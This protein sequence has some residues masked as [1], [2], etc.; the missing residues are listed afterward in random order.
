M[1]S[2]KNQNKEML[3]QKQEKASRIV[4]KNVEIALEN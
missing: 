3:K 2:K 1:L 4:V